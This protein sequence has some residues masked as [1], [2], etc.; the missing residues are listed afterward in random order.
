MGKENGDFAGGVLG[1]NPPDGISQPIELGSCTFWDF[2]LGHNAPSPP[3]VS[4]S[5]V[6]VGEAPYTLILHSSQTR[7]TY[8]DREQHPVW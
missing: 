4:F 8:D 2:F 6:G 1:E 3:K 7:A 5:F